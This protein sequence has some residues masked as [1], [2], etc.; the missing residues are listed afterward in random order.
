[1]FNKDL[2]YRKFSEIQKLDL[3][4]Q[5]GRRIPPTAFSKYEASWWE[6][7]ENEKKEH[8][9]I[10]LTMKMIQ[11]AHPLKP[12]VLKA[13]TRSTSSTRSGKLKNLGDVIT[14]ALKLGFTAFGGIAAH[15]GLFR[16]EFVKKRKWLSDEEFLD[17]LGATNL[18]PGPN[19]TEMV[20]HIGFLRA[21][22][23]G[24][25]AAGLAFTL[26]AALMVLG[27]AW[28]YVKYGSTPQVNGLLYGIKPVMIAIIVQA[29]WELGRKAIKGVKTALIAIAVIILY[30]LGVNEVILLFGGGL[31]LMLWEG[32]RKLFQKQGGRA[33]FFI[34]LI[35]VLAT[36]SQ[37]F[38]LTTLFLVF[39]KI[40]SILYGSGYVLVAFLR[41]DLVTRLGWLSE[42]QLVDAIAVGQITPGPL[43]TS[44][45][46]IG[47]LLGGL[48]GAFLA[49]MGI[50]IPSVIFVAISNPLI[51]KI[52]KSA[53]AGSLL[54]GVVAASIG[55]IAVAT[56]QL[57]VASFVDPITIAVGVISLVILLVFRINA[58]WLILAGAI[59]GLIVQLL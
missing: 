18:I 32:G 46:F 40:G 48:T 29:L 25:I 27:L 45:T 47:Y 5:K 35:P 57:G 56:W 17:L 19:S 1:M 33:A 11:K 15:I 53:W 7:I 37:P 16:Q 14:S 39:L 12:K 22:W 20:G 59:L 24:L 31:A 30:I 2:F 36:L 23:L 44:A 28:A 4:W 21:G 8:V 50:F 58:T 49:T 3:T 34:P 13:K 9:K 54:D 43:Y 10:N 42:Q 55:L 26:P 41:A 6:K 51:P 38:N 52:R